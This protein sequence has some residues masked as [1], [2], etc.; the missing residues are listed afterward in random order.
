MNLLPI[1]LRWDLM[2]RAPS[3]SKQTPAI[4]LESL[5]LSTRMR[6]RRKPHRPP[7]SRSE[8]MARIKSKDT[9]LELRVRRALWA[10]GLRY[11][12]HDKKLP[13]RPDLVF[14]GRCAVVFIH[15]C[16]WHC[17][18]GCSKHRIPKTRTEWWAQ[19]LA[20]NQ[21][22]DAKVQSELEAAGWQVLIIWEC[23]TSDPEQLAALVR[24]LQSKRTK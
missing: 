1:C 3:S 22:R 24:Q 19:K 2:R 15:G 4:S 23:Q 20:R 7:L 8:I 5:R 12:L 6:K 11:R 13:G 9:A 14:S 21:V 18:E 16:F 17:H 10:A